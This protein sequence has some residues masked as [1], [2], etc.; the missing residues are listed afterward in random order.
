MAKKSNKTEHVLK[1]IS[2][3]E[4]EDEDVLEEDKNDSE[5]DD[6]LIKPKVEPVFENPILINLAEQLVQEKITEVMERMNVCMCPIC[7]ND[8]AA[9]ALNS[10]PQKYITTVSGKQFT[11]IDIYK[12]QYETDVLAAI[13]KA[14]VRVK[15]GSRHR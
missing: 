4:D 14:C 10:L 6:N 5:A 11:Q 9:L 2:K 15:V 1:L 13:T 8:I 7:K 3:D 12:K